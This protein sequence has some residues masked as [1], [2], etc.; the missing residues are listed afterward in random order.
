MKVK[1]LKT[2]KW[3][4]H[5]VHGPVIQF[6]KDSEFDDTDYPGL[7][8]DLVK[9]GWA[10][11]IGVGVNSHI[12]TKP[13]EQPEVQL[14]DFHAMIEGMSSKEAKNTLIQWGQIEFGID[15][16]KRKSIKK[17]IKELR[18]YEN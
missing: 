12:N 2:A 8:D 5:P 1:I 6:T 4:V 14:T 3:S 16:D 9:A 11:A 10:E 7:S 13:G 17:I 18:S 15:I